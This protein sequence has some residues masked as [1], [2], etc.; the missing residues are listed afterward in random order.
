[1]D[2]D[3]LA[4]WRTLRKPWVEWRNAATC[5]RGRVRPDGYGLYRQGGQYYG[6][7]LEYDRGTM[8][9]RGYREKLAAYG[10][11]FESGRYVRDYTGFPTILVIAADRAAEE[12]IARAA[13]IV[14]LGRQTR[15]P[16]LLTAT[17][18][19]DGPGNSNGLLSP[20]W[21]EID[22]SFLDR[23]HWQSDGS[24]R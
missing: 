13:R 22:G 7:F 24:S 20:I 19:I 18:R 3:H 21:R 16:V 23:R 6:F 4:A 17:W 2:A 9:D 1:M 5:S 11:Y 12:R 15:I 10:D 8:S 14:T